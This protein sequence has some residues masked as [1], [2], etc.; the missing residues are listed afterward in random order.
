MQLVSMHQL[1]WLSHS[2]LAK[3]IGRSVTHV[4]VCVRRRYPAGRQFFSTFF[5][6]FP[7]QQNS[8]EGCLYCTGYVL[9]R[10]QKVYYVM[11][12]TKQHFNGSLFT[13]YVVRARRCFTKMYLDMR[14]NGTTCFSS[15]YIKQNVL[16]TKSFRLPISCQ[17]LIF[18]LL[19]FTAQ[20]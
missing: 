18:R 9:V 2:I 7:S 13:V 16:L 14:R 5:T 11:Y 6:N 1:V 10:V 4:K 3:K 12:A 15:L 20:F 8:E 19:L 17:E